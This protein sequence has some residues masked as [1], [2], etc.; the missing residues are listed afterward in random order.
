MHDID[1]MGARETFIRVGL[2]VTATDGFV[3]VR[4]A[5]GLDAAGSALTRNLLRTVSAVKAT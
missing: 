5:S 3:I 2:R 4:A 1:P